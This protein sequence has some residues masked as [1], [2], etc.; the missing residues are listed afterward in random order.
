M[1]RVARR[2][3]LVRRFHGMSS[4]QPAWLVVERRLNT[5]A[6]ARDQQLRHAGTLLWSDSACARHGSNT[7]ARYHPATDNASSASGSRDGGKTE[8]DDG[9][10]RPNIQH[11]FLAQRDW[12]VASEQHDSGSRFAWWARERFISFRS[13]DLSVDPC[14]R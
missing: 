9:R 10:Q 11:N 3:T 8:P 7:S 5:S 4:Q 1:G 2:P 12:L 6:P 14:P 13:T